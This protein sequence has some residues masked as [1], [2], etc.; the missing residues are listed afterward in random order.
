MSGSAQ[1]VS[2]LPT[3]VISGSSQVNANSVT[4]F[5]ANVDTRLDAKTVIS[6]SSQVDGTSISNNSI[7]ISGTAVSLGGAITDEVLF[8]GVGVISGSGQILQFYQLVWLVVLHKL[9]Q[10]QLLT[11]TPM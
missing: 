10:I 3:G 9:M 5:D 11:L 2:S 8:G 1:I 7:T 4:N 6:G